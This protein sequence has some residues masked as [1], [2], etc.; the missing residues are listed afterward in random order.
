MSIKLGIGGLFIAFVLV[1]ALATGYVMNVV[2]FVR[3][4]FE[5]PVKAEILRGIGIFPPVGAVMGYI[6]IKDGKVIEV[7]K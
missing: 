3:L 2:K 4:D 5:T 1:C 7:V 6:P